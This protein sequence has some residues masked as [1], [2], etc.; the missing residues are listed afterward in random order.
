MFDLNV[1]L[2]EYEWGEDGNQLLGQSTQLYALVHT[3]LPT[4]EELH[5]VSVCSGNTSSMLQCMIATG[6]TLDSEESD[7]GDEVQSQSQDVICSP[8]DPFTLSFMVYDTWQD[9]KSAYNRYAKK[10]KF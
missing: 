2:Q 7:G 1:P 6:H 3:E 4:G 9:A 5:V 8:S 10:A